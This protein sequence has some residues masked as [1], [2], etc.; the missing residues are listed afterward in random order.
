MKQFCW[1]AEFIISGKKTSETSQI[2]Q[3]CILFLSWAELSASSDGKCAMKYV[4]DQRKLLA[5]DNF[6]LGY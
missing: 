3:W 5:L 1:K 2:S 4:D 6:N